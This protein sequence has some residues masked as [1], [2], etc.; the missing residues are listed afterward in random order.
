MFHRIRPSL[1]VCC[2]AFGALLT[3]MAAGPALAQGLLINVEPG[4]RV[5]L[6]RPHVAITATPSPPASYKIHEIDVHVKIEEQIARVQVA[7]SFVNTGSTQMEVCFVFPLPYDGAI[8]QLTLLVDGKEFP[9]RLLAKDEARQAYEAIVR[10]NRD[11]ALLEWLGTGMFKTSVFP[12]PPGAERKVTLRYSQLCRKDHGLTDF[13]FPLSTAKY[14]S[15][16]VERLT[17]QATIETKGEIKNIYSPTHSIELKRDAHHATVTYKSQNEI[18]S[19]DFRL[20]YDA[21]SG[22][23]GASVLSYR[24]QGGDDGYFLLLTTPAI[25]RAAERAKKTVVFVVDRS[26]SMTGAKIEQA[27]GALKFV[28]NNLHAGDLF[29][30]IAYDNAVES[31]RPELQKFDDETR[32]AALGFIEGIYA[33]GSTNI[34]GALSAALRQLADSSRPSYVLFLTDGLPTAGEA[35]EQ[36]IVANSQS[37]NRVHARVIAFGVGYDVNSRLL[38]KLVR[39]NY[40][41]SE[42]V[43][44]NENIEERVSRLYQKIESPVMT[45]VAIEFAMDALPTE[46]GGAVNRIYPKQMTDLFAGEQLVLVGRYKSP[47]TAKVVIRGKVGAKTQS[48]DFPAELIAESNDE[49]YAF[50]EK[51]WAVRR[52][53]EIID[54]LDLKGKNDELIKELV[55]LSTR[56]GILTPYTSFLADET[57]SLNALTSNAA[58]ARERLS[59]L[60]QTHGAGAF[61]QRGFKAGLQQA[62]A[63]DASRPALRLAGGDRAKT[64]PV[65]GRAGAAGPAA[66]TRPADRDE[67][68]EDLAEAAQAVQNVGNKAFYR[69]G[70]RWVD[71]AVTDEQEK[72]AQRVVQFS[73]DYFRLAERH[74]H[75]LS[76][77]LVFDEPVLVAL[78]GEAYLVEPAE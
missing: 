40:G 33:G 64:A 55:T 34:D 19:S 23:L 15:H 70:K 51:L 74:G 14:T 25:E 48:V 52:V 66:A 6:P 10:K 21:D 9:A 30:I 8:D 67:V 41:Q 54:E 44:P 76:Q 57:T 16:P 46:A 45:D 20:L 32:K 43:R 37:H 17:I 28:L 58:T 71:A 60:E 24:P 12:V 4:Q 36:K 59:L 3:W 27:K 62:A 61:N 42:Y 7:Q 39:E 22:K 31:F 50:V 77:Y 56:H 63:G 35:N 47:G 11:P 69:R 18:P 5:R 26:G 2:Y 49:S 38:D 73:D 13:L 1:N 78:D 53:G 65:G 72:K 75:K 29:N 68:F